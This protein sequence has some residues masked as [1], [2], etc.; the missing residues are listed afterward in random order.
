MN[1]TVQTIKK[2][3]QMTVTKTPFMPVENIL[4]SPTKRFEVTPTATMQP[5]A[6]PTSRNLEGIY[7]I[8][9]ESDFLNKWWKEQFKELEIRV[10]DDPCTKE[11]IEELLD[12]H[13]TWGIVQ[14]Y[15]GRLLYTHSGWQRS[16]PEFGEIFLHLYDSEKL[17]ETSIC[18]S[19]DL[20]Y[21]VIDYVVLNRDVIGNEIHIDELFEENEEDDYFIL[22]CSKRILPGFLTPKLILQIRKF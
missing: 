18:L 8:S 13:T 6:T 11:R 16:G 20:C 2:P 21:K 10:C 4:Y 5:T 1:V 9:I 19:K 14:T 17:D 22:T 7:T 15:E 12:S 3:I